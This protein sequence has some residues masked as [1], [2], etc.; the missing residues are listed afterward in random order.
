[1]DEFIK[2][3]IHLDENPYGNVS[4]Q[5][6]AG[7]GGAACWVP[8]GGGQVPVSAVAGGTDGETIYVARARHEGALI[9]G[10]LVPSHGVVYIAWG[11]GEHAHAE[12]E[13]LCGCSTMWVPV[14]GDHIPPQAQPAGETEAGEPLFVGRVNHEG[15]VTIGKV[16]VC[17][18]LE[19]VINNVVHTLFLFCFLMISHISDK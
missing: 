1:M 6:Q 5:L 8:S 13:V 12:Y 19:F 15:A 14:Q 10:K 16:Q 17:I 3:A 4:A 2:F 9:P 18:C 11:G 7:A